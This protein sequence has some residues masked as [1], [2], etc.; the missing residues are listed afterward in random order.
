MS[1]S[2][3]ATERATTTETDAPRADRTRDS[4]ALFDVTVASGVRRIRERGEELGVYVT[5]LAESALA[6]A[7]TLAAEAPRSVLH[8]VP[9]GLKDEWDTAGIPTTAGS[10]RYR[11]R[12]PTHSCHVHQTFADAG[13]VLVGKTNLS[14]MGLAPEAS[15]Y[16]GGICRNPWDP[17][18]TAGGSSGGAAAGVAAGMQ[19]FDWGTDIGGSIRMPAGFC[20]L[21]GLRLS[22]ETWP[23]EDLF[24]TVPAKLNWMCGQGPITRTTDQMRAV[25]D[26]AAP[27]LCK[28]PPRAFSLKGAVIHEPDVLG[29][30]PTFRADVE[31]HVA[32]A[33]DGAVTT[34]HELP[35]TTAT[36][37]AYSAVWGSHFDDVQAADTSLSLREGFRAVL[38]AVFLRG[39][40]GDKRFHPTTAELLLLIA[41][42]RYTIFRNREKALRNAEAIRSTYGEIWDRGLLVVAPVC[43]F[44]APKVGK[45]NRNLHIL[46]CTVAGNISDA[47]G[48][49]I[50]FG[51]F[52][53]GLPRSV[54]FMGPPGSERLLLDIADR[55]IKSRDTEPNLTLGAPPDLPKP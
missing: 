14:D 31:S 47:T 39:R 7:E 27:R 52:P 11:D 33:I 30:W 22:A 16:V 20:G 54:Q 24:P 26:V 34:E 10:Y 9:Y 38:S 32:A 3:T 25:L 46:S 28:A 41:L 29:Q 44:P 51:R 45:T 4:Q 19:A 23:I 49:A 35:G 5:A 40:F 37:D 13:A 8:G 36:R 53:D 21:L 42:G 6:D 43:A 18:R 48:I 50:P 15:S 2:E 55:F 17:E 1:Q 12:T